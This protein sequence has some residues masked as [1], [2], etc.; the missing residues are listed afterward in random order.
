MS[1]APTGTCE[2]SMMTS[3]R[4]A[5]AIIRLYFSVAAIGFPFASF[6]TLNCT[7]GLFRA[8]GNEMNPA[9]FPI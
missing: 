1:F 8:I 5:G 6:C 2:K 9:S 3:A 4:S 7:G